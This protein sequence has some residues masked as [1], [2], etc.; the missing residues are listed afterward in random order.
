MKIKSAMDLGG[1]I[2]RVQQYQTQSLANMLH[3]I[4]KEGGGRAGFGAITPMNAANAG[5]NLMANFK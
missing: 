2:P 1:T 4:N 3:Q 5:K